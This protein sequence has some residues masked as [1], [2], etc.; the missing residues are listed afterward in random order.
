MIFHNFDNP[1]GPPRLK[2]RSF[3]GIEICIL[4][5]RV[6]EGFTYICIAGVLLNTEPLISET[7]KRPSS[8]VYSFGLNQITMPEF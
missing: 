4:L 5:G 1:K 6:Q 3:G 8:E 7:A 2:F